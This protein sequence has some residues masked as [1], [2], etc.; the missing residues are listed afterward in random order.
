MCNHSR[1]RETI[2]KN[3]VEVL[4]MNNIVIETENAFQGSSVDSIHPTK[5]LLSIKIG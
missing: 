4:E 5:E 2:R 3:Q 1:E